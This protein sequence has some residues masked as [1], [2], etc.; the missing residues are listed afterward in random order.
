[1]KKGLKNEITK[2]DHI[3]GDRTAALEL[4]EYGDYQCP[5]CGDSYLAV[6]KAIQDLGKNIVF[7][8]RNFPL[9][10]IHP[11][12]FDAA[13]AA[14]AAAQQNKF[15]EMYTQL[16]QNQASLNEPDLF[17]Y[18]RRIGLDMQRFGQ[19]IQSQ[20]L[21]SKIEGDIESGINSGVSGTP[22]FYINGKKFDGDWENGGLVS[23]LTELLK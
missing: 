23:Y 19:D 3:S 2:Y 15:W 12:A 1:M 16:F 21:A 17:S 10:D 13:M 8:F 22:S 20:A 6:N 9:T 4:L 14:E 7:V 11:D 5:S 18:A